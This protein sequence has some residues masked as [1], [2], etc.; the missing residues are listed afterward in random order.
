[1]PVR[2]AA[3][4]GGHV[5]DAVIIGAGISGSLMA[6]ELTAQGLDVLILEAG[7]AQSL[8]LDGY[9][10]NLQRYHAASAKVPNAPY[11]PNDNAPQPTVLDVV[12]NDPIADSRGYFVQNGPLPFRSD[13]VRQAGGT[14]LHWLGT[15]L[16]MLPEDFLTKSLYG[17]GLDWP[18][19][20]QDLKPWYAKAEREIGVSADIEDQLELQRLLGL[21]GWLD[22]SYVYPMHRIP[23]SHLD[24]VFA[25]AVAKLSIDFDGEDYPIRVTSTP[26][27]RNSMPNGRYPGGYEPVGAV[28]N[29]DIGQRCQGN[30]SCVPICPVQAKYNALKTL[31]VGL[32]TGRL[33][34]VTQ[35]VASS[36]VLEEGGL[37]R[38]VIYKAYESPDSP[39]FNT[40]R[41]W[42]RVFILAAHAIENAKLMLSSGL[43]GPAVGQN[44]MDHPVMLTW[45]LAGEYLGTFRG[46]GSTSGI[47]T[48]RGGSFR[49]RRAPFRI[50]IDNWGWNWAA[51]A[52]VSTVQDLVMRNEFG[53]ELRSTL[54]DLVQRQV[55]LGFLMEVP[56]DPNNRVTINPGLRDRLDNP[57]PV[58][59][60]DLSGYVKEG[61]AAA[62]RTSDLIFKTMGIDDRTAYTPGEAGFLRWEGQGYTFQGAGHCIGG[63]IMGSDPHISVVDRD[64]RSWGHKNLWLV[65]CGNMVTEGTAN[66]T[67]TMA[68]LTLMA[69][70]QVM[71]E[72]KSR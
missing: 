26:Q 18:I 1:M 40:F 22:G 4:V 12:S 2:T 7:L 72:F 35:A 53:A 14:T 29:P 21:T 23:Q 8:D 55:R 45:G 66:P 28:G 62:K 60:F 63:H 49:K 6:K 27:G 46:P 5:Y 65:G 58:L 51:N 16:R 57:R 11:V 54:F 64:Q 20:Y 39:A 3:D 31:S 34:L 10:A 37:V 71:A 70:E 33:D 61:L 17:V 47:E 69:S 52:P 30:S 19:N 68:A 44:L 59:S 42:G 15:C 24:G 32:G 56:P 9:L 13:Y 43:G 25:K 48:L 41:A 38:E 67:L 50:E 36:L